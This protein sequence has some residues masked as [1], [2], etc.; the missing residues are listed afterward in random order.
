MTA[1]SLPRERAPTATATRDGGRLGL[2]AALAALAGF[3]DAVGFVHWRDLFVSFMS[4]NST[5]LAA[6]AAAGNGAALLSALVIGGF[7]AGVVVGEL[8]DA[9]IGRRGGEAVLLAVAVLLA[10]AAASVNAGARE[11]LSA[12]MLS[13]AMGL[14]NA[15]MHRAG[16]VNVALTYVTGTLVNIGRGV[17]KALLE[18]GPW[19]ATLP[20]LA[21]WCGLVAGAVAG[22]LV[23]RQSAALALGCAAAIALVLLAALARFGGPRPSR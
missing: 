9:A 8:L 12:T 7:V 5:M 1:G 17:A 13:L 18:S 2:A 23:A 22:A 14:Q 10:A 16:G 11:T 3:V 4:G 19:S 20:F 6:A 21:L 15:T